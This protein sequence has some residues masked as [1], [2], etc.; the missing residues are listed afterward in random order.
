MKMLI[1]SLDA[2]SHASLLLGCL[3]EALCTANEVPRVV[4]ISR[5]HLAWISSA[6]QSL[7]ELVLMFA[8]LF[9]IQSSD[10]RITLAEEQDNALWS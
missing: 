8:R 5:L 6:A 7:L 2:I 1:V 4:S 3:V 10:D 9:V